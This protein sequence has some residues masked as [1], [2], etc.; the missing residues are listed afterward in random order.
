MR[1]ANVCRG[2]VVVINVSSREVLPVLGAGQRIAV[3]ERL[4]YSNIMVR[5]FF[6]RGQKLEDT[7][8]VKC[9]EF[10]S[11]PTVWSIAAYS[12][13]SSVTTTLSVVCN[14]CVRVVCV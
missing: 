3:G 6:R 13:D 9:W 7:S 2:T 5:R 14:V 1:T 4:A 12:G 10:H 8:L 11:D